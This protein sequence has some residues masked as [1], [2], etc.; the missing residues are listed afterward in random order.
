MI[1]YLY[2]VVLGAQVGAEANIGP[3]FFLVG[4][5]ESEFSG[6]IV[7]LEKDFLFRKSGF[8][9]AV[10]FEGEQTSMDIV[11][12]VSVGPSITVVREKE[13]TVAHIFI[14]LW[15]VLHLKA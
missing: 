8:D 4:D 2:G 6:R 9:N 14:Y 12:W 10:L 13:A 1:K 15:L 7:D 3:L 5:F 11:L